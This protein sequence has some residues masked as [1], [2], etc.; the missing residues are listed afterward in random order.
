MEF[1]LALKDSEDGI[2]VDPGFSKYFFK[3]IIE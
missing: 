3:N 1:P 2:K